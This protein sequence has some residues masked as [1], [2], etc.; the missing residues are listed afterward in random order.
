MVQPQGS[1]HW[2]APSPTW[3][4][5]GSF[6]CTLYPPQLW[7]PQECLGRGCRA[8]SPRPAPQPRRLPS[9]LCAAYRV[10]GAQSYVH[11]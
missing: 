1:I 2:P 10:T 11:T 8:C 6:P 7:T 9:A 3:T 5:R 4:L